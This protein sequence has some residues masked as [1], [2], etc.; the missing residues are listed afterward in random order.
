MIN[1]V[2]CREYIFKRKTSVDH[3]QASSSTCWD[4]IFT[5][6]SLLSLKNKAYA[7]TKIFFL[8]DFVDIFILEHKLLR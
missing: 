5:I 4:H 1:L 8:I 2:L 6:C 3:F 7:D